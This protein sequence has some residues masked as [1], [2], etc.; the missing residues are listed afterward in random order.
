[1]PYREKSQLQG[2]AEGEPAPAEADPQLDQML[3]Q[4]EL[5]AEV[6]RRIIAAAIL[7]EGQGVEAAYAKALAIPHPGPQA[8][9]PQ[10]QTEA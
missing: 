6:A 7:R 9:P 10:R 4:L 3:E 8:S 5:R 2:C 1:V